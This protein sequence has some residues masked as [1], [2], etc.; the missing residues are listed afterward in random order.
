MDKAWKRFLQETTRNAFRHADFAFSD[1]I[2]SKI[3]Q[4]EEE[5]EEDMPVSQWI[6]RFGRSD[7]FLFSENLDYR[8][9][10]L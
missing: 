3:P 4:G 8:C 10:L 9:L 5:D 2:L 7:D 6:G 1:K